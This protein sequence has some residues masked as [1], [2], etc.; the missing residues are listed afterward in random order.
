LGV[1]RQVAYRWRE[2]WAKGGVAALASKVV[3]DNYSSL[4]C[5]LNLTLAPA[6]LLVGF[7]CFM[8]GL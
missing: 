1:A 2:A 3:N 4:Q 6:Y 7:Y 8:P 5:Q